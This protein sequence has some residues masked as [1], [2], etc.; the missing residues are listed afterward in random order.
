MDRY[1]IP[2]DKF[3]TKPY[4]LFEGEWLLLTSGDFAKNHFNSM[5]ISWGSMGVMWGKPFV[6]VVVRPHRYTYTFMEQHDSFTL[7]AFPSKYHSALNL[8]GT[9]SGRDSNKMTE[10]GLVPIASTK[11]A[12]PG[13][14]EASL[15]IECQKI[16]WQDFDP[17][18]F[19]DQKTHKLYPQKDYH[20]IYYGEIVAIYGGESFFGK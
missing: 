16:Y 7:C 12:A 13:Y 8:L 11:V 17:T 18:H 10:S 9:K 1:A 2:L 15:I 3:L 5:T 6:Q 19:L 14:A 4:H 20:R